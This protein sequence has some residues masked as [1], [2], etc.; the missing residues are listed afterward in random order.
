MSFWVN[1]FE[2]HSNC[3][4][5]FELHAIIEGHNSKQLIVIVMMIPY[6]LL[7][8]TSSVSDGVGRDCPTLPS[9]FFNIDHINHD[10]YDHYDHISHDD[11]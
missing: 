1:L 10:H 7:W 2:V 8:A 9:F 4:W 5:T 11:D 3:I 6:E